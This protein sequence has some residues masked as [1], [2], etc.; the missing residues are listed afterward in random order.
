VPLRRTHRG[1]FGGRNAWATLPAMMWLREHRPRQEWFL[2][3]DDD[4]YI[5]GNGLRR[6]IT[7][8]F[9]GNASWS[10]GTPILGGSIL[11]AGETCRVT[12]DGR[13]LPL[14]RGG[15][16]QFVYGGGGMLFNSAAV[17]ALFAPIELGHEPST[18]RL[19]DRC[20]HHFRDPG[21]DL[22]LSRCMASA[23]VQLTPMYE[24]FRDSIFRALGEKAAFHR[25][26]FP[27][28][29]HGFQNRVLFYLL[30]SVEDAVTRVRE[31][32]ASPAGESPWRPL[33]PL[34]TWGDLLCNIKPGAVFWR[35]QFFPEQYPNYTATHGLTPKVIQ[36]IQHGCRVNLM[37]E[38]W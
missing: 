34:V 16:F 5:L 32:S 4:T 2:L 19:I 20:V 28:S 8:K 24:L 25:Y 12:K 17:Q 36:S 3:M 9:A 23:R 27:V 15:I 33:V 29:F 26:P 21:G 14:K 37:T 11:H 7:T 6:L 22:R 13:K 18:I 10:Q 31:W 35:S 1:K 38:P 30:G